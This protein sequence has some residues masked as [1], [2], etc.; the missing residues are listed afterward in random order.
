MIT[1]PVFSIT[2]DADWASEACLTAAIEICVSHNV[3]PTVFVTNQSEV[4][5]QYKADGKRSTSIFAGCYYQHDEE[6]LGPQGNE[7]WRGVW[8]LHQ[9]HDGEYDE[10]P[11]S[12]EY[13]K[14]KYKGK[15]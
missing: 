8:V 11:V 5:K 15:P 3:V 7:C 13:L 1:K 9:V 14:V 12:I 6:Y 2:M 4:L 10:M